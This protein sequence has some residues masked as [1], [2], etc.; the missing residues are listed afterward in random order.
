MKSTVSGLTTKTVMAWVCFTTLLFFSNLLLAATHTIE[1]SA[2]TLPN[3]QF[4]YQLNT[5]TGPSQL[6][7][8]GEAVIPG[9]T[10]FVQ[11]GDELNITLTNNTNVPVG[12]N[13]PGMHEGA[14]EAA[15]GGGS[16]NYVITANQL[17]AHPYFDEGSQLLG[18]FGALVVDNTDGTVQSYVDGDGT[19]ITIDQDELVELC[20]L[21]E[22]LNRDARKLSGG[23][24]QR[25]LLALALINDPDLVFLDEPTTGLHFHDISKLMKAINALIE[26]GN[27]VVIIEHN[28]EVIKAADWIIDLGP[29]GGDEGGDL[30]HVQLSIRPPNPAPRAD[31]SP[32]GRGG[33]SR[34]V[35]ILRLLRPLSLGGE[36]Q[37]EGS[38]ITSWRSVHELAI[39][40]MN[41]GRV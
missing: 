1:M 27:Y 36:G 24:R 32:K 10:L 29:E 17:G 18:L 8:S 20:S 7:P 15:A 25:L 14:A 6:T 40:A 28:T 35:L 37:G 22:F 41:D 13:I 33:A 30:G 23:Q 12:L 3:G 31:L 26:Q 2:E 38:R 21:G 39:C 9:P 11:Q 34:P 4:G 19:I 5:Y 16:Q